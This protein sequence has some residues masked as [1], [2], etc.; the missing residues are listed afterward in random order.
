MTVSSLKRAKG[1]ENHEEEN[2]VKV[3]AEEEARKLLSWRLQSTC[4]LAGT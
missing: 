3:E 2:Q 4:D 1:T